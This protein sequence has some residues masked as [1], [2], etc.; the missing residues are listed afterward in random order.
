M[1]NL[2]TEGMNHYAARLNEASVVMEGT[3][4]P[5][6]AVMLRL[7]AEEIARLERLVR[8]LGVE[9]AAYHRM[10]THRCKICGAFWRLYADPLDAGGSWSLRSP[11]CGKCCDNVSMGEQI[12]SL[13]D[14]AGWR[15]QDAEV[16]IEVLKGDIRRL[17]GLLDASGQCLSCTAG[18]ECVALSNPPKQ[19]HEPAPAVATEGHLAIAEQDEPYA[20]IV[21]LQ[22][23]VPVLELDQDDAPVHEYN[24]RQW[25][26]A[27]LIVKAV[28]AYL[29]PEPA[30]EQREFEHAIA[31]ALQDP[32][33]WFRVCRWNGMRAEPYQALSALLRRTE[34]TPP[35]KRTGHDHD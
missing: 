24:E 16:Y 13:I 4:H 11:T 12:V 33:T 5:E 29:S 6:L 19:P 3:A 25:K 35:T 8:S 15:D 26:L 32:E 1:S 17:Q 22:D 28:N 34:P 14:P 18:P 23:G 10:P 30:A 31:Y 21:I 9:H 20:P 2:P 7:G 27:R